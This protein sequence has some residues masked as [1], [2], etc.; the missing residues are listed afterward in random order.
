[1]SNPEEILQVGIGLIHPV[2]GQN[3]TNVPWGPNCKIGAKFIGQF[4]IPDVL[5][6]T[7][8]SLYLLT[9][10]CRLVT[11][12]WRAIN[13]NWSAYCLSN[14]NPP[15]QACVSYFGVDRYKFQNIQIC[16]TWIRWHDVDGVNLKGHC[17]QHCLCWKHDCVKGVSNWFHFIFCL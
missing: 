3:T 17:H 7:K 6:L 2:G 11:L 4:R 13:G 1:M 8:T 9:S 15:P 14:T 5:S 12:F 10:D 16:K